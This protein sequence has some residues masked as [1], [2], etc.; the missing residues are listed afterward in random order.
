VHAA[1]LLHRDLKPQNVMLGG[2][3]PM[4]IDFG[5]G[6]F[7]DASAESLSHSGMIVGSVRCMPPEQARGHPHVNAAA[8]VYALGTVLLYAAA[9]H[10][11]YDGSMWEAVAAQVAN[12]K[13][14]PN[15]TGVPA[16]LLPLLASMLAYDPQDR[17]TLE[18][19]AHSCADLLA[20]SGIAPAQARLALIAHTTAGGTAGTAEVS[21]PSSIEKLIAEQTAGPDTESLASPLDAPPGVDEEPDGQEQPLPAP[22]AGQAVAPQ[23]HPR[24][25]RLPASQRVSEELRTQYAVQAA[26]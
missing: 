18:A 2:N 10:Y 13:I 3:G 15:L 21:L 1:G 24:S 20:T 17:P 14:A 11:P 8:D 23:P 25:A 5:L 26:L 9:G 19:I 16:G 12:P 4:I 22:P 7:M 6:A